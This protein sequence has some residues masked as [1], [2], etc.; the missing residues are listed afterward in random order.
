MLLPNL[1]LIHLFRDTLAARYLLRCRSDQQKQFSVY[2]L[3]IWRAGVGDWTTNTFS[4]KVDRHC[5]FVMHLCCLCVCVQRAKALAP[6]ISSS[7]TGSRLLW[8]RRT[9]SR[10]QVYERI[11]KAWFH[12]RLEL[13]LAKCKSSVWPSAQAR[14]PTPLGLC[15]FVTY[16]VLWCC[17]DRVRQKAEGFTWGVTH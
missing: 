9:E 7:S 17:F 6:R 4:S 13:Q 11:G 5:R 10:G 3:R 2:C 1:P 12:R 16:I 8:F 14:P 15:R